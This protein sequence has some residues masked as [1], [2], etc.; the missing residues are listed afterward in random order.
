[1]FVPMLW[2]PIDDREI[3][4]SF[5]RMDHFFD[6]AFAPAVMRTD[7][8]EEDHNYRLEAELP[9]YD[10]SDIHMELR[11]G[12]LEISASRR[13]NRDQKDREGRVL[14]RER[15]TAACR[16]SFRVGREVTAQD[17]SAKFENGIL[18]VIIPK[19]EEAPAKETGRIEIS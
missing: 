15:R 1:M 3:A 5:H 11:D 13:E 12:N 8:T 2:N 14:R 9:G 10:K 17:I 16:R 18:T 6:D 19:K 4:E 7:I